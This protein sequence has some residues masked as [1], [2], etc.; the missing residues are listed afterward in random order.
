MA[1]EHQE[2]I[3]ESFIDENWIRTYGLGEYNA[4]D[5]FACSQFYDVSCNNEILKMQRRS[6]SNLLN[7]KGIE[8]VI[9]KRFLKCEPFLF[10]IVKQ[11]RHS[12]NQVD[13]IAKYYILDK[14][15]YEC[16]SLKSLFTSRLNSFSFH[17]NSALK[18]LKENILDES[19]SV[20][21]SNVDNDVNQS[22]IAQ[23][24][25]AGR[26][27]MPSECIA[28]SELKECVDKATSL[29]S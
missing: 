18:L 27:N 13:I 2:L 12:E 15:I 1:S 17:A 10:I 4:L 19:S 14:I 29:F 16:P 3:T 9:G 5:Y 26:Q 24:E 6:L 20:E 23:K 21:N 8:Y 7:M 25:E 28:F 22:A 11:Q